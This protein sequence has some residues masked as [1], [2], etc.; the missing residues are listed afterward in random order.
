MGVLLDEVNE[1]F[2][3]NAIKTMLP[4]LSK[5][6]QADI[7]EKGGGF[8]KQ[9]DRFPAGLSVSFMKNEDGEILALITAVE[10]LDYDRSPTI[11]NVNKM[12]E[13]LIEDM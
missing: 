11:I 3:R 5:E 1:E 6:E 9:F 4:A 12:A 2:V 13:G 7:K 10:N 8:I